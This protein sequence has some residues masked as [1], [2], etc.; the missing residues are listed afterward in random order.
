MDFSFTEEQEAVRDL[1]AQILDGQLGNDALKAFD[2]TG[3]AY[4]A[5]TWAELAK[6]GL[7]GIA[8][9]ESAGGADLGFLAAALVLEQVGRTAAPVPYLPTVVLGALPVAEFGTDAQQAAL[10]P[11]VAE[12]TALLT[13][14]LVEFGT[15][16]TAPTT[17]ARR[18]GDGWRLDGSKLCVPMGLQADRILVPAAT[19]EGAVGVFLVDPSAPG[20]SQEALVTTS[21]Q[22][23]TRLDLDGAVVGADDVLGDPDR[24]AAIVEWMVERATAALCVTAI[25]VCA[26]ALRLTAEYTKTR[27]Q[28]DRPI[29]TFQA[30][31]QRAAD[32]YIDTEAVRLTAWQAA[33]RLAEGLPAAESVAIAKFWAAEGGQRVVHAAQHLHGGMGVDRDYPLHRYFLWAKQLELT[34]GG[35]TQHLLELGRILADEPV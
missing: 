3:E 2:K 11:G 22:P 27:E 34:L 15:S 9:P 17:T 10:L 20:V 4:D 35:G 8:L 5:A 23:E 26:E 21:G 33:W 7:L 6:A 19:G 31:G 32:A 28:F 29:A 24:G 18:D 14:A 12:G 25:G 1:A 16:P 13:A 30:V